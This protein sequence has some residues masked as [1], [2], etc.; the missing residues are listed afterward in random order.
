MLRIVL[1]A[2][3]Q[4]LTFVGCGGRQE[5]ASEVP[6]AAAPAESPPSAQCEPADVE[7]QIRELEW[8]GDDAVI[9]DRRW[10]LT[11][12]TGLVEPLAWPLVERHVSGSNENLPYAL[13]PSGRLIAVERDG[14]LL[15]GALRDAPG[16]LSPL[17][18]LDSP[19]VTDDLRPPRI[20]L[21]FLDEEQ[22]LVRRFEPYQGRIDRC[23][24]FDIASR[25]WTELPRCFEGEMAEVHR[26]VSGPAGLVAIY[27][28]G[29]GHPDLLISR[30]TRRG[31]E[32]VPT[33]PSF[34]LYPSAAAEVT[35]ALSEP[36]A[37]LTTACP[38]ERANEMNHP[39]FTEDGVSIDEDGAPWNL[40][41]WRE[42]S[43][44][45]ERLSE[46]LPAGT[47]AGPRGERM[48]WSRG[49]CACIGD[50]AGTEHLCI[51]MPM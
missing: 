9:V 21:A 43:T 27:S 37:W 28:V 34:S 42:G 40:Y 22:V 1:L 5:P 8:A 6:P 41:R 4:G 11:P 26:V 38:L 36:V 19:L 33:R 17:P 13:S 23:D 10:V 24:A 51:E 32:E 46:G 39:C 48:V 7:E 16:E 14:G 50:Q 20:V 30:L 49:R 29:E 35:F 44:E 2:L 25:S 18:A 47:V 3:M 45:L 15:V 12:S 31:Q